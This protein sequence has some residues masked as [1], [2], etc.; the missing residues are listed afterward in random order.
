V[1]NGQANY[2]TALNANGHTSPSGQ[3]STTPLPARQPA[4]HMTLPFAMTPGSRHR[5][6][7]LCS[8]RSH[9]GPEH[10]RTNSHPRKAH[11]LFKER[12]NLRIEILLHLILTSALLLVPDVRAMPDSG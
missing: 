8:G 1:S 9:N 7:V 2:Y 4:R 3:A 11:A 12:I 5:L 10:R 6:A